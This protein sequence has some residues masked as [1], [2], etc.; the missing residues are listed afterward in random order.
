MVGPGYVLQ[1]LSDDFPK[2]EHD[3]TE[4]L[5][6]PPDIVVR[7]KSTEEIQAIV[8]LAESA[9]LPIVPRGGGTGLSGGALATRG[10]IVLSLDRMDRIL[11]IDRENLFVVVQPGIITQHLQE[12]VEAVGL[13][14]PP[15]P[16]SRGSCTIGG[17]ISENAGG[18]RAVKYG[19]TKDYVY[20]VK[21]VVSGGEVVSFGGKRLK[22]VT[23]YN[24]VQLFVGSEGTLGVVTEV[25]LKLIPLP[26]YHRTLLAPFADMQAAAR[27]VPA[28]M[29]RGIVPCALEFMEQEALLAIEQHRGQKVRFSNFAAV[30]L[31]E[32]DGHHEAV[33]DAEI[34]SI[35]TVLDECGAVDCFIAESSAQQNEIWEMRRSAGEATKSICPY[36]EVDAVV[37]RSRVP[38]LVK[39]VHE[40]CARWGL[41]VICYGHA[42]DGNVHCNI[43]KANLS[44]EKWTNELHVPIAELFELTVGLGGTLSGEHGIGHVQRR[45]LPIAQ[46]PAEIQWQRQLKQALDPTNRFNPGKILPDETGA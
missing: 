10:G 8:R 18:P 45:F 43:L 14:Y 15:D 36:K 26:K 7:P 42:G 41:R 39:G 12:A 17:N 4:D 27:A 31:I 6:F 30:L 20:G 40:I 46:T 33:L 29:A 9:G 34:E 38:E 23:G 13:F 32:V 2:Y 5:R 24:M 3:E 21:A 28:I 37:P 16:A 25:T 22:D 35:A 19:V 44:D 11:E 1:P